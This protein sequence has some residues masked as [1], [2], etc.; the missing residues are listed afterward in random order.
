MR[1]P[2]L[3]QV[4]TQRTHEDAHGREAARVSRS[5]LREALHDVWQPRQAQAPAW[6][7]RAARVPSTRLHLHVC[8]RGQAPKTHEV[9]LRRTSAR[10]RGA[11]LWQDLQH[12][13]ESQSAH[14]NPA[15]RRGNRRYVDVHPRYWESQQTQSDDE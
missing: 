14:E 13:G 7:H 11:G 12:H 4:H 10:L 5:L 3:P 6:V 8:E 2:V 15:R 1:P 9:P